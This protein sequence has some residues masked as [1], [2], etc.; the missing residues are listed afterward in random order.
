MRS[1]RLGGKVRQLTLLNLGR[2]FAVAPADWPTLCARLKEL[3][4]GQAVLLGGCGSLP[5]EREARRLRRR[6]EPQHRW[7]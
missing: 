6:Q 5:I 4:S 2:H 1:E 3:L 7:R